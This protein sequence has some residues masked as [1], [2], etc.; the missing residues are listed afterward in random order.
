MW[1]GAELSLTCARSSPAVNAISAS[2]KAK[3]V[4]IPIVRLSSTACALAVQNCTSERSFNGAEGVI[5]AR[6]RALI[7]TPSAHT[8]EAA[9]HFLPNAQQGPAVLDRFQQ[10]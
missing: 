10:C 4:R 9:R 5:A 2:E 3:S 7:T 6:P 8:K 1:L